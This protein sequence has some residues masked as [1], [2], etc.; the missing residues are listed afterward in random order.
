MAEQDRPDEENTSS[1]WMSEVANSK[2]GKKLADALSGTLRTPKDALDYIAGADRVVKLGKARAEVRAFEKKL[3]ATTR[4]DIAKLKSETATYTNGMQ[5]RKTVNMKS[6]VRE[7]LQSLPD[8]NSEVSDEPVSRDFIYNLFNEFDVI[9][10]PEVHKIVGK[11]LA[12]E[13]VNPGSFPRRTVRVLRDLESADF[14]QF[15]NLCRYCVSDFIPIIFSDTDEIYKK[16][17]ITFDSL[18]NLAALGLIS[19]E[20]LGVQKTGLPK[21]LNVFYFDEV[22]QIGFKDEGANLNFGHV[23]FTEAGRKLAPLTNAQKVTGFI[24][25]LGNKWSTGGRKCQIF[26]LPENVRP[27]K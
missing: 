17:G 7:A 10:D 14:R 12:G 20:G 26:K 8:S 24:E 23:V 3:D 6:I 18:T 27:V 19:K 4:L 16:N 13:I 5:M 15:A 22:L 1:S 11:L 21:T 25:Y 9:S 2:A